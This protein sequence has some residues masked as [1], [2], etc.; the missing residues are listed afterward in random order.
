MMWKSSLRSDWMSWKESC[1]QLELK[2]CWLGFE[3]KLRLA[4]FR[5][6]SS[7][8]LHSLLDFNFYSSFTFKVLKSFSQ[9]RSSV[10]RQ[11]LSPRQH[12]SILEVINL[13]SKRF[14]PYPRL[15][16]LTNLNSDCTLIY[17]SSAKL[18]LAALDVSCHSRMN[19]SQCQYFSENTFAP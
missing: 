17:E 5:Q 4:R 7:V 19:Q 6:C 1:G 8:N 18:H 12:V 11:S 13:I 14:P 10:C 15:K 9:H 3:G 16:P 2:A